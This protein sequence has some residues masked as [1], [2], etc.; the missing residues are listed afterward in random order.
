M[1]SVQ[2]DTIHILTDVKILNLKHEYSSRNVKVCLK[3]L[4]SLMWLV[5]CSLKINESS[6]LWKFCQ[7]FDPAKHTVT[8][9]GMFRD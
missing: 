7:Q 4:I 2:E 1:A 6:V 3:L 8:I 5:T 9:I